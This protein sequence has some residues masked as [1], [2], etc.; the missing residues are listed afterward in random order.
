MVRHSR[1]QRQGHASRFST[2]AIRLRL[3]WHDIQGSRLTPV[4]LE[5]ALDLLDDLSFPDHHA[6]LPS[7]VEFEPAKALAADECTAAIAHDRADVEAPGWLPHLEASRL[8]LLLDGSNNLDYH[9]RVRPSLQLLQHLI[10][11]QTRVIDQKFPPGFSNESLKALPG[12]LR[13]DDE[14]GV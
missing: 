4:G 10:V 6:D 14:S 12:V 9:S 3:T 8:P 13:A 11:G 2:R 1:A 5:Y 7:L